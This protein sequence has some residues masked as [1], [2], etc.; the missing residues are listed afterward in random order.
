MSGDFDWKTFDP[1]K[2]MDQPGVKCFEV[3]FQLP[4]NS[5]I[6]PDYG[7]FYR[8]IDALW[9]EIFE[10]NEFP[11]RVD[12]SCKRAGPTTRVDEESWAS[13]FIKAWFKEGFFT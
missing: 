1:D 9:A 11:F 13:F 4:T 8:C 7:T 3:G 10:V 2:P 12:F 6:P 5:A